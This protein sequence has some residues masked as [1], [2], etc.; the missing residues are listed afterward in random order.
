M[1]KK[2]GKAPATMKASQARR[3]F[4]YFH[5]NKQDFILTFYTQYM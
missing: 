3:L 4:S 5:P 2:P 1:L